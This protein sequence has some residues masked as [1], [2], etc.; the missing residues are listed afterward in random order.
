MTPLSFANRY[1]G[2]TVTAPGGIGG[3]CVDLVNVWL[4]ESR[5]LN[6]VRLNAADWAGKKLP[7]LVWIANTPVNVPPRGA[8]VVWHEADEVGIGPDGHIALTLTADSMTLC[9]LDQNWGGRVVTLQLHSYRGVV[10]WFVPG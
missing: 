2:E 6:P 3:E 5:Q 1:L 4:I 10:G 7:G 8:V 9:T